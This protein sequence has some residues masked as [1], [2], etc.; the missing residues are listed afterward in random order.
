MTL[1]LVPRGGRAWI[2]SPPPKETP[3]IEWP[4][5]VL[6]LVLVTIKVVVMTS[7]SPVWLYLRKEEERG[8]E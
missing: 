6:G 7:K 1:V 4:W 3:F 8:D 5:L 2:E